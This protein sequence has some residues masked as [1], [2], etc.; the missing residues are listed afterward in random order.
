MKGE[1]AWILSQS[2]ISKIGTSNGTKNNLTATRM[3]TTIDDISN[4]YVVGSTW[5]YSGTTYQCTD[6]TKGNAKWVSSVDV[7]YFDTWE[8]LVAA[9]SVVGTTYVH[10]YANVANANNAPSGGITYIGG[11]ALTDYIVDGGSATYKINAQGANYSVTGQARTISNPIVTSIMLVA[12]AKPTT[13]GYYIFTVTPTGC[14]PVGIGLN[15]IAYFDGTIWSLYQSY[16]RANTVLVANDATGLTQV[17][18][19]KFNGTWM[20]TA[21]EYIADNI[22]YQTGKLYN[23]KPVYRKCISC[24]MTGT[25]GVSANTGMAIPLTGKVIYIS[26]I[27]TR[28]DNCIITITGS[29]DAQILVKNDCNVVTWTDGSL[30]LGRPVIVWVEYTKN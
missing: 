17:T 6:A 4:G 2:A 22:G 8:A 10:K 30:Y 28:S 14:L 15:D 12:S 29:G 3:P 5:I 9:I 18:W 21:E 27:C 1:E 11:S 20:S 7:F 13:K 19:R 25:S 26:G 23:G 16:S 24:T